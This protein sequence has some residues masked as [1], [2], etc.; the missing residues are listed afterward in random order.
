MKKSLSLFIFIL[1]F[2]HSAPGARAASISE[3]FTTITN[4]DS[5]GTMVWNIALG[6][7]HPPLVNNIGDGGTHYLRELLTKNSTLKELNLE[8]M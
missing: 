3:N 2:L 4:K 5:A 1:S 8:G 7:L 6:E